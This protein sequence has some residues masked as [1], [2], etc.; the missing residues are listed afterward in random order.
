MTIL[1]SCAFLSFIIP[2]CSHRILLDIPS[3]SFY[4][5]ILTKKLKVS[6][7]LLC[8]HERWGIKLSHQ[9]IL[10]MRFCFCTSYSHQEKLSISFSCLRRS[11]KSLHLVFTSPLTPSLSNTNISPPQKKKKRNN[12]HLSSSHAQHDEFF[13]YFSQLRLE[14]GLEQPNDVCV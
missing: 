1:L 5:I 13:S 12:N 7:D 14:C 4:F 6:A 9:R 2:I 10:I 3:C 8:E 11:F